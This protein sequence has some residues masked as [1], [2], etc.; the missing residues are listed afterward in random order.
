MKYIYLT[1]KIYIILFFIIKLSKQ[2]ITRLI[3]EAS[4]AILCV[5]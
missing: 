1:F 5:K 3:D 2:E 4:Y